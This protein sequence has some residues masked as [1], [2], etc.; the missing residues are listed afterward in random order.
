MVPAAAVD[1]STPL[2]ATARRRWC[3]WGLVILGLALVLLPLAARAWVEWQ[4][5]AQFRLT[6]VLWRRWQVQLLSLL[7]GLALSALLCHWQHLLLCRGLTG[8]GASAS[9][10]RRRHLPQGT[11]PPARQTARA[12]IPRAEADGTGSRPQQPGVNPAAGEASRMW[13]LAPRMYVSALVLLALVALGSL[14]QMLTLAWM[15]LH[16]PLSVDRLEGL[17]LFWRHWPPSPLQLVLLAALLTL[18]LLLPRFG[19]RLVLAT[20]GIGAAI[21]LSRSWALWLRASHAVPFAQQDPLLGADLSYSVLVYPAQLRLLQIL[22][23]LGCAAL[24]SGLWAVLADGKARN[25]L[26]HPGP[27]LGQ[28]RLLRPMAGAVLLIL[29]GC[30][31]LSRTQLMLNSRG[32]FHGAGWL[33]VHLNL[34]L[35]SITALM[36]LAMALALLIPIPE[37]W[38]QGR[39]RSFSSASGSVLLLPILLELFAPPL[40]RTLVLRPRELQL[41]LPYLER[42]IAATRRAFGLD[43]ILDIHRMP[44]KAL[45]RADVEAGAE[46][47]ANL[48]LWDDKPLLATNGQLQQLRVYYRFSEPMVDRYRLREDA[49]G[50]RQ[51]VFIAAREL[52]QSALPEANQSWLNRHL[53][54]THGQGFTVSPVNAFG[55]DR[56]PWYFVSD[57][58]SVETRRGNAA[59]GIDDAS[60]RRVFPL[61]NQSLYFGSRPSPYA[62]APSAIEEFDYPEGSDNV[63]SHYRGRAGIRLDTPLARLAA[64]LYLRELKLLVRGSLTDDTQLL[65]R[66]EV[67]ERLTALAPFLRFESDPYLVNVRLR[68]DAVFSSRQHQFWLVDGFT[69]SPSYPYSSPLPGEPEISYFRNPVKAVVDAYN[70]ALRIYVSDQSDPILATWRRVFPDLFA[71]LEAMPAPLREHIRYPQ[72]Q[73]RVVVEQL[74]RFHVTDPRIFYSGDA[75]WELP[76]ETYGGEQIAVEPYYVN[77]RLSGEP[78]PEFLLLQPLTP[79]NRPNLVAWLAARNDDDVYGEL[80]NYLYPTE[81]NVYGPQQVQALINQVPE[82]SRQFS[83]WDRAGSEVIQGNLLLVPL[84]EAMLYVEP[85]YL[86]ASAGGLPTLIRVVVSDGRRIAMEPSLEEAIDSLL[87]RPPAALTPAGDGAVTPP[88]S[89]RDGSLAGSEAQ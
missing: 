61:G 55:P 57:L 63:Y 47:L 76:T 4:W 64:A 40:L 34:P 74:K 49:G 15:L 56:L 78:G 7:G 13:A 28:R 30:W 82:I 23:L 60:V 6:A 25:E 24:A 35:R 16:Q 66:R 69:S 80:V 77:M 59:L 18:M 38:R 12:E 87:Q 53:V 5:F 11:E 52:E 19:S 42:S 83:L 32:V 31:W 22:L 20:T 88:Q 33:E 81:S 45:K 39:R 37:G 89:P 1:G 48:R 86:K 84:G 70:G 17:S 79:L 8:S 51:Q 43:R 44:P 10:S 67:R 36:I 29:A 75:I 54:F 68:D 3:L 58:G 46:T 62:L 41:Q 2:L 14:R 72:R 27:T 65:L 85:I 9:R 71:P 26:R 50:G 73:F 21:S